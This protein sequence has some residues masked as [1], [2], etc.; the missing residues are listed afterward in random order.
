MRK[1]MK[2]ALTVV[3][4]VVALILVVIAIGFALPANHLARTKTTF[5]ASPEQVWAA[6]TDI[7]NFPSWRSDVKSVSLSPEST[8]KPK[9]VENGSNGKI[10]YEH[11]ESVRPSRL[12]VRLTDESLPFGGTWTY[13]LVPAVGGTELTI[14]EDGIV[15]NPLFRFMSRYVFGHYSTQE[16]YLGDLAKKLNEPVT[17]VTREL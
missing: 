8:G 14:T 12:R 1:P 6:I 5:K 9:W 16:K 4:V 2:I 7:E 3:V 17:P 11:T 15:R 13:E 10:S